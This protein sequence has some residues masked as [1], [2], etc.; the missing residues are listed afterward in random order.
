MRCS[1]RHA[2]RT[3]AAAAAL[4]AAASAPAAAHPHVFIE[5]GVDFL[6]GEAERLDA[7][8]VTWLFDPFE[9]LYIMA[10]L[11]H[12][13]NAEGTL[14]PE[15]RRGLA[16]DLSDWP[17]D[18]SGVVHLF[19]DGEPIPL[20]GPV[21]ADVALTDGRLLLTY[22]RRLSAPIEMAALRLEAGFYEASYFY[23]LSLTNTPTVR[24]AGD[25]CSTTVLPFQPNES[26]IA[27][28]ASLFDLDRSATPAD[29]TVGALF[30]DR[31]VVQCE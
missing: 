29:T 30:A 12:S 22:Q 8:E 24:G 10:A 17:D 23:A 16:R 13:P 11:G 1:L 14:D 3:L 31:I 4:L 25:L 20:D 27:L 6:V 2:R 15:A 21:E 26:L 9:T 18:F 5:G 19:A 28:Q 7:V